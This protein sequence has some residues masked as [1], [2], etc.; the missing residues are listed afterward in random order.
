MSIISKI[1]ESYQDFIKRSGEANKEMFGDGV[2]YC[3]KMKNQTQKQSGQDN[4]TSQ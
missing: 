2:P 4:K 3:C 1:K